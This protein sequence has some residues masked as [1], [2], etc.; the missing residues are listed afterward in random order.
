MSFGEM[1]KRP[2][3][4][5]DSDPSTSIADHEVIMLRRR[6]GM[7]TETQGLKLKTCL[8]LVSHYAQLDSTGRRTGP[9]AKGGRCR[10]PQNLRHRDSSAN[11]D[12]MALC[13]LR[14]SASD[15]GQA[16]SR[17]MTKHRTR[18]KF[19]VFLRPHHTQRTPFLVKT[20][21]GAELEQRSRQHHGHCALRVAATTRTR[22]LAG[23]SSVREVSAD[24]NRFASAGLKKA[25]LDV[26]G[27]RLRGR[28]RCGSNTFTEAACAGIV[29]PISRNNF[30]KRGSS[31]GGARQARTRSHAG[32][33]EVHGGDIGGLARKSTGDT[34]FSAEQDAKVLLD[35]LRPVQWEY[36]LNECLP[37]DGDNPGEACV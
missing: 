27:F 16:P 15:W 26:H 36:Y 23:G 7:V 18:Q 1:L 32:V 2:D 4:D 33:C 3:L 30:Y 21:K 34:Q 35:L 19:A 6:L 28:S 22:A 10:A 12:S 37:G 13:S 8:E 5:E 29:R 31:N 20:A 14:I 17:Q 11:R 9:D 25:L 24:G